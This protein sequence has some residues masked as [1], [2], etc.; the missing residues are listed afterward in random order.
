VLSR[1]GKP[2][3]Q[4]NFHKVEKW[5]RKALLVEFICTEST[6]QL[7]YGKPTLTTTSATSVMSQIPWPED[8]RLPYL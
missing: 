6:G 4:R 8:S 1:S 7:K 5:C 2:S 3:N